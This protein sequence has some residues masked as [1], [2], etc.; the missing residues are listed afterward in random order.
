MPRQSKVVFIKAS[1]KS[2]LG[3]QSDHMRW[4]WKPPK[5]PLRPMD[6]SSQPISASLG[7]PSIRSRQI[8]VILT[9][10]AHS[11]S[12]WAS[13]CFFSGGFLSKPPG[14]APWSRP[15]LSQIPRDRK[16]PAS[17]GGAPRSYLPT[18]RGCQVVLEELRIAERAHDAHGN[19]AD[20]T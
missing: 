1:V 10:K 15:K 18:R 11:S 6:S 12:F 3:C 14:S 4:P 8:R 20:A 9:T 5:M 17:C 7:L 13:V 2:P 19:G 16:S